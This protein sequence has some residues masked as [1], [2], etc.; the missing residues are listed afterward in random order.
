[1]NS[2]APE[3]LAVST[4]SVTPVVLLSNYTNIIR[5][6]NRVKR[7]CTLRINNNKKKFQLERRHQKMTYT[8]Q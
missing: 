7:Q 1:V 3:G 6:G 2:G 5:Y 4:Q 8:T